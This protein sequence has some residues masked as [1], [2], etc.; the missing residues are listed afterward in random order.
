MKRYT[1]K[2]LATLLL[3]GAAALV[4]GSARADSPSEGL[5]LTMS[6]ALKAEALLGAAS[7]TERRQRAVNLARAGRLQLASRVLT[8]MRSQGQGGPEVLYDLIS[9]LSWQ[10]AHQRVL[11]LATELDPDEA[12]AYALEAVAVSARKVGNYE[13]A[14]NWYQLALQQAPDNTALVLGV[15]LSQADAGQHDAA[16][17]SFEALGDAAR[18]TLSARLADAYLWRV[19]EN[20]PRALLS[21]D[22][23]LQDFPREQEA[24]R[25]K[26]LSLRGQLLPEQALALATAHPGIARRHEINSL[27]VDRAALW[28]RWGTQS[29]ARGAARY[30]DLDRALLLL[31]TNRERFA[32]DTSLGRITRYDLVVALN[33]RTRYRDAL[34]VFADLQNDGAAI[35]AYVLRAAAS[36]QLALR[37][38]EEAL[39]LY[40][41]ALAATPENFD[42]QVDRFY[43]LVELEQHHE[44][45]QVAGELVA[46]QAIWRQVPG[47][48]VV[49]PNPRRLKAE[50]ARA[51]SFAYSDRLATAQSFF[52]DMLAEA[53]HNTDVRQELANVYRWRGWPRA[54]LY[55][56]R[57]VETVE[58]E[59]LSARIG[60]AHT[61]LDLGM[62][63]ELEPRISALQLEHGDDPGVRRLTRRYDLYHRHQLVVD[64]G[65]GE[66]TGEQFGSQQHQADL[67]FYWGGLGYRWRPFI[68]LHDSRAEFTEGVGK[69]RRA[70]AGLQYRR[71]GHV[72]SLAVMGGIEGDTRAG[73]AL[74]YGWQLDDHWRVDGLLETESHAM[75]LRG[76]RVGVDA[77]RL[78]LGARFRLS[79]LTEFGAAGEAMDFSD[80]NRRQA[81]ILDARRRI[82]NADRWQAD[83]TAGYFASRND[84]SNV[85]YYSPARDQAFDLGIDARWRMYRRYEKTF[86]HRLLLNAGRY[87]QRGFSAGTVGSIEYRPTYKFSEALEIYLGVKRARALYDGNFEYGTFFTGGLR[88]RF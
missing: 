43:A 62:G 42:L 1:D 3:F 85:A 39:R 29:R 21:Y 10:G 38:P 13:Q 36:A 59:L 5:A 45:R 28:V 66:S 79:E 60:L 55:Q 54:A 77:N 11:A 52:D 48:R 68:A 87:R 51:L 22:A 69:R 35:P 6:P 63:A 40:D 78:R 57:Q 88:G 49:K 80:G 73:A 33:A 14:I 30:S 2:L 9:V 12:P 67:R 75:P 8:A 4:Y 83:L 16:R 25:G 71:P 17:S 15:A 44:A 7:A 56:Y 19:A 70:G 64:V 84:L 47:S 31:D 41:Q 76:F 24:L 82:L 26:F 50:I 20:Y 58:P 61:L 27:Y 74:E 32:V 18:R 65:G 46:D 23:V 53:P 86:E 81:W 72:L 34:A 37:E